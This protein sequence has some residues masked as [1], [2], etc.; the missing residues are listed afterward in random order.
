MKYKEPSRLEEPESYLV[1]FTINPG[2]PC[3]RLTGV[4]C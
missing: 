2:G 1:D 3:V 4:L